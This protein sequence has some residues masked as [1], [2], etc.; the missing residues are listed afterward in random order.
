MKD[1]KKLTDLAEECCWTFW[2]HQPDICMLSFKR[3]SSRIN[4]YYTTMTIA[5]CVRHPVKGKTQLFRRRV[6]LK[7][8]ERI[9]VNPRSHT[10]KG[11]Y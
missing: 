9:L 8:L 7:E 6:S 1:L 4:I 5:T 11:Y 10:G 2:D 3:G